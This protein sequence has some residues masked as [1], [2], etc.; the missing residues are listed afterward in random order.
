[1][2]DESGIKIR[3]TRDLLQPEYQPLFD[4]MGAGEC[5]E[6]GVIRIGGTLVSVEMCKVDNNKAE[7]RYM[8]KVF[9]EQRPT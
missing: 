4:K 1:M 9:A 2:T 3:T 8:P 6:A 7:M 5:K